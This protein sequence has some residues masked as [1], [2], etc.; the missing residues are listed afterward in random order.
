MAGRLRAVTGTVSELVE[1]LIADTGDA[2]GRVRMLREL[3]QRMAGA[4]PA[5]ARYF[6]PGL[7][8]PASTIY[9]IG[10]V[11]SIAPGATAD[12]TFQIPRPGVAVGLLI[13]GRGLGTLTLDEEAAN[14]GWQL[15]RE[16]S[17]STV[18]AISTVGTPVAPQFASV[19]G[20]TSQWPWLPL[21]VPAR[22]AGVWTLSIRNNHPTEPISVVA[23]L[24]FLE[25]TD[26]YH[27]A[28]VEL[29]APSELV[30]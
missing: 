23:N 26:A 1:S 30:G 27:R 7:S 18:A 21:I 15:T 3:A 10:E 24:A 16:A 9:T 12:P 25:G 14:L 6:A 4:T 20:M 8:V 13:S 19:R 22:G 29:T 5:S 17:I 11:G 28:C 2:I